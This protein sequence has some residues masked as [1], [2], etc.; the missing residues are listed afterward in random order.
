MKTQ[1]P[2]KVRIV[3]AGMFSIIV[4]IS[5]TCA[6]YRFKVDSWTLGSSIAIAAYAGLIIGSTIKHYEIRDKPTEGNK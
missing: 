5:L 2:I 4:M 3:C 1:A 6:L